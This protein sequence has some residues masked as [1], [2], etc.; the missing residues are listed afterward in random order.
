MH[1][2]E[3]TFFHALTLGPTK[4][5]YRIHEEKMR[6]KGRIITYMPFCTFNLVGLE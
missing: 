3:R 6:P 2:K 5:P 1:E 4:S